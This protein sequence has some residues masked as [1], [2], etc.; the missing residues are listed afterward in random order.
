MQRVGRYDRV[1]SWFNHPPSEQ[2]SHVVA[3]AY[4]NGCLHVVSVVL[5]LC[6]QHNGC[7][8]WKHE[9]RG[10]AEI[11]VIPMSVRHQGGGSFRVGCASL[12]VK[13]FPCM[14]RCTL[15]NACTDPATYTKILR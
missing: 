9:F 10:T 11:T 13:L 12:G 14:A 2:G 6:Q 3:Q 15:A 7:Q 1:V 5:Q 4:G 8:T